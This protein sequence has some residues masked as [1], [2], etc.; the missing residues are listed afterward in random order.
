MSKGRQDLWATF[1]WTD[2][3][4]RGEFSTFTGGNQTAEDG[5][6]RDPD[7]LYGEPTGSRPE[8]DTITIGRRFD[9]G[10]DD[11]MCRQIIAGTTRVRVARHRRDGALNVVAAPYRVYEGVLTSV[12][13]P[14]QDTDGADDAM[15]ELEVKP[16]SL[17]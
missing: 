16:G 2:G 7:T 3:V 13:E 11:V 14:E 10:R 15:V 8:L 17:A 1:V 12:T 5:I 4:Y 9:W 6:T